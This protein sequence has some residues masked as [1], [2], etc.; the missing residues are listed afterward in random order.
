MSGDTSKCVTRNRRFRRPRSQS[1]LRTVRSCAPSALPSIASG[2]TTDHRQTWRPSTS[3]CETSEL[4]LQRA[5]RPSVPT[6]VQRDG[7][8]NC[9]PASA[10]TRRPQLGAS[11]PQQRRPCYRVENTSRGRRRDADSLC[12]I[13]GGLHAVKRSAC[14]GCNG[15]PSGVHRGGAISTRLRIGSH[16]DKTVRRYA[17]SIVSPIVS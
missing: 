1:E 17:T 10:S 4:R 2:L 9:R 15:A 3:P 11:R 7:R 16:R 13:Y 8:G 6:R 12:S 14:F 5:V